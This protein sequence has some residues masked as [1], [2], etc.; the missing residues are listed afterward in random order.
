MIDKIL[1]L[2][3]R[4]SQDL[5]ALG[6]LNGAV[7]EHGTCFAL[8]MVLFVCEEVFPFVERKAEVSLLVLLAISDH[9]EPVLDDLAHFD[10][11]A[12]P[13]EHLRL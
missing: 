2:V 8:E 4:F 3:G 6:S 7:L 10:V 1:I 12:P 11:C 9:I 5:K 13:I